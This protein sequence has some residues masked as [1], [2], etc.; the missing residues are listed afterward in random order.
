MSNKQTIINQIV[1]GN[2]KAIIA[3]IRSDSPIIALN[4]IMSGTRCG[5][6][7]SDFVDGV[8]DIS[9]KSSDVIMD[10]PL[11]KFAIAALHIL[12]NKKYSGDDT[13]IKALIESRFKR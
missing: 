9:T 1:S 5:I 7:N 6:A 8:R 3:G 12:E 2:E 10:I 11:R 13:I 4:A